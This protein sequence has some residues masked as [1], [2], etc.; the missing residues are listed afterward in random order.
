[1]SKPLFKNPLDWA[2]IPSEPRQLLYMRFPCKEG[3]VDVW[4]TENT[5]AE[6]WLELGLPLLKDHM[7]VCRNAAIRRESF[8]AIKAGLRDGDGI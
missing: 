3:P 6:E 1:M 8:T 7:E 5:T 2:S 4:L